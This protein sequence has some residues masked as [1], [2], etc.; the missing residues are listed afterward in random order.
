MHMDEVHSKLVDIMRDRLHQAVQV[1]PEEIKSI[2]NSKVPIDYSQPSPT[3]SLL[4]K[5]LATL[6][7]VLGPILLKDELE[8]VFGAVARSYSDG[9]SELFENMLSQATAW[10]PVIQANALSMLQVGG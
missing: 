4:T 7:G 6:R 9:L 10:E 5:Q 8:F 3:I 1:L 2:A